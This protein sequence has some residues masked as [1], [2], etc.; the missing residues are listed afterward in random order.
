MSL[1]NV[2]ILCICVFVSASCKK[3]ND[4]NNQTDEIIDAVS[5]GKNLSEDDVLEPL[6]VIMQYEVMSVGDIIDS[7]VK[8]K[9]SSVSQTKGDWMTL[10]IED[11]NEVFVK[12]KNN[13][14]VVPKD[15]V[16]K[17]V[18]INGVAYIEDRSVDKQKQHAKEAGKTTT[19]IATISQ[20]KRILGFEADGVL[21]TQ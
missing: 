3:N 13:S 5:F 2:L 7:K 16:G 18:I 9:V 14:F 19:Q 20:P 15:I 4:K 8:G 6:D 10:N 11:E 17:E 1:K 12:F 21:I